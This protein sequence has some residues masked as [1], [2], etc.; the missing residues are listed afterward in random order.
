MSNRFRRVSP[1]TGAKK[2]RARR[3]HRSDAGAWPDARDREEPTMAKTAAVKYEPEERVIVTGYDSERPATV[4][5]KTT[6]A[7]TLLQLDDG[8]TMLVGNQNIR[9]AVR[10]GGFD[11]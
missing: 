9:R 10:R 2:R 11:T 1:Y 6:G 8:P 3:N 7:A 4:L 5:E